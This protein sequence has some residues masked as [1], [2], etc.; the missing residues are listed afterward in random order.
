MAHITVDSDS[1]TLCG[2]C[3]TVCP[4]RLVQLEDD[5][6]RVSPD[7][8]IYCGH[9]EAVCPESAITISELETEAYEPVPQSAAIP[10]PDALLAF[11]RSRRSTRVY[12]KRAVEREKLAKV[13]EAARFAPTG[14]NRQPLQYTVVQDPEVLGKV[15]DR[16]IAFHAGNAERTLAALA[17]KEKRHRSLSETEAAAR[18]YAELWPL[19]LEL[20]RQGV[21]ALFYHAPVLIVVHADS[22]VAPAPQVD[23]ALAAMQMALMAEALGL[24]T[25]FNG[26]LIGAADSSPEL[27]T[28]MQIPERNI[29][30]VAFGIGYPDIAYFRLVPRNPARI[31]W[32]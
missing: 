1:C 21:D 29:P 4:R 14:G 28:L 23:A 18:Q 22:G 9:C 30:A 20:N 7:I 10:A 17:D 16:C 32:I 15:R 5:R 11:L 13:I 3:T 27:K 12:K 24:G 26:F 8:C 19:R 6:I 2:I 25:C 31:T